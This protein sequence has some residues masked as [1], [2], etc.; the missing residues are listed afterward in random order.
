[1]GCFITFILFKHGN[2]L[3]QNYEDTKAD[4]PWLLLED[5]NLDQITLPS[6]SAD[7]F[8]PRSRDTSAEPSN[9]KITVISSMY[10]VHNKLICCS[11]YSKEVRNYQLVLLVTN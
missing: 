1:M 7:S 8:T 4:L 6:S 11:I 5:E 9:I 10:I 3:R 2:Q